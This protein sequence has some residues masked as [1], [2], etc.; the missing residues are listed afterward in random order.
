MR[1]NITPATGFDWEDYLQ[2]ARELRDGAQGDALCEAKLRSAMSRSYYAA[3]MIARSYLEAKGFTISDIRRSHELVWKEFKRDRA[4]KQIW[5]DGTRLK[6]NRIRADYRPHA[7]CAD[8]DAE[9][10]LLFAEDIIQ[11][12]RRLR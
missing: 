7:R 1:N 2:L 12:I 11:R 5:D 8:H 4:N 3:Y 6:L 9:K 10:S